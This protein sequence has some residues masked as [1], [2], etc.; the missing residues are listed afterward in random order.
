MIRWR[1]THTGHALKSTC[2]KWRSGERTD[3]NEGQA[4][5]S[6]LTRLQRLKPAALRRTSPPSRR[7]Q[8][9]GRAI[10]RKLSVRGRRPQREE[11]FVWSE[12]SVRLAA[13]VMF[14][15][16]EQLSLRLLPGTIHLWDRNRGRGAVRLSLAASSTE[17]TLT[18]WAAVLL[19]IKASLNPTQFHS[20]RY[21]S[22]SRSEDQVVERLETVRRDSVTTWQVFSSFSN[23]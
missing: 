12:V 15:R 20:H 9:A 16:S 2:V 17:S 18:F 7:G 10:R 19:L 22:S 11:M 23:C 6:D 5:W 13:H 3:R 1:V 8:A 14:L 4:Q 21:Y